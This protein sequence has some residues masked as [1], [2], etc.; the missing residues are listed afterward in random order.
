MSDLYTSKVVARPAREAEKGPDREAQLDALRL[1]FLAL[2]RERGL[3]K[4]ALADEQLARRLIREAA[5]LE[6][7]P[8]S[9]VDELAKD[10]FGFGPISELMADP[11]V[12]DIWIRSCQDVWYEKDGKLFKWP[13]TFP[14]E[15]ALKQFAAR[16]AALAGRKLDESRP[17]EDFKMPDGSRAVVFLDGVSVRGTF[18]AVRRFSRLFT[19]GELAER[20]L[21]PPEFVRPFELLVKARANIMAAGGMGSG[22][23]TFLYALLL[24]VGP[25]ERL[26][27]VEDPA[28]TRVGLPDP[29]RPWLPTPWV[30]VLEPKRPGPEGG[31]VDLDEIFPAVLRTK[32]TRVVCSECRDPKTTYWTLQAMNIG[33]PGSMSTVHAE[34]PAEVPLRLSD[35][36][37]AY[38]GGAYSELAARAG[39]V[40]AVELV[41]FL[42]QIEG[43]RR[44][45]DICEVRRA[46]H[47]RLPEVV[48]LF[49]FRLEGW[50]PGNEPLGRLEPTGEK[51]EFLKKRK[52]SLFLRPEEREELEVFFGCSS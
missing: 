17:K 47:D 41:F 13:E 4:E 43:H 25:D 24:N 34:D 12:T 29:S 11:G 10:I 5:V 52:V 20:G 31:G 49:T 15:R 16:M 40:A 22:K 3:E 8:L 36:L 44:L 2:A 38:R 45:L 18:M 1:R 7:L 32:P 37:A 42:G 50:G 35:M 28:E 48:P 14:S 27:F 51:P 21:F 46:A 9:L 6:E 19:L 23:N 33:H 39:R 26:V 30:V